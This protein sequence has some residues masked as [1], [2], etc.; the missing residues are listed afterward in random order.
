MGY[1]RVKLPIYKVVKYILNYKKKKKK[2]YKKIIYNIFSDPLSSL[3]IIQNTTNHF[4]ITKLI[5][6]KHLS[7]K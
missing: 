4:C 2:Q 7:K 1:W 6:E 3:E 5:Q